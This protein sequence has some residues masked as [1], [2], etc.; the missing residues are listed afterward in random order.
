MINSP[1][2]L[3]EKNPSVPLKIGPVKSSLPLFLSQ[4]NHHPSARIILWCSCGARLVRRCSAEASSA[5]EMCRGLWSQSP[6]C[7]T[8]Q[9]WYLHDRGWTGN[10]NVFFKDLRFSFVNRVSSYW[11]N[12]V[13]GR[14][15]NILPEKTWNLL[16]KKILQHI[17]SLGMLYSR[18]K[19]DIHITSL[20]MV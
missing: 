13:N 4:D 1:A 18:K 7:E 10:T 5:H 14:L 17:T 8:K 2:Q 16:W 6:F 3:R 20:G 9:P 15:N 19:N 12:G 11:I